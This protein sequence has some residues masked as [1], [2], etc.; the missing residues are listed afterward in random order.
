M[1]LYKSVLTGIVLLILS[2][3]LL[4]SQELQEFEFPRGDVRV[5]FY[6]VENLFDIYNDSL[7]NDDEFTP[8]GIRFWT[9]ERYQKKLYNISKV[10]TAIG[11]WDMPEII[12]LSEIENR[13]VLDNLIKKTAL[14]NFEYHIIHKESPDLRGIDVGFLYRKDRFKPLVY[15][16]I[17]VRFPFEDN[18]PSR[19]ILYVEGILRSSDTLH[20]FINHWPSRYGGQIESDRNREFAAS[21]LRHKVD[22]LFSILKDP[23]IIIIGDLNDYPDNNSLLNVLKA[24]TEFDEIEN[25]ELY[26]LS[27]YLQEVKGKGSH[28]YEGKWG[29]LDQIII[30]GT[31]LADKNGL[32][33]TIENAHVFEAPFLLEADQHYTGFVPFRTYVG[34]KF[35]DGYSDHL[36]VYLDLFFGK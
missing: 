18:R 15:E 10:I 6:N 35:H 24:K 20:F 27:W 16:A 9:Y 23:N 7:K 8:E 26:N 1:S 21:V 32:N 19:D 29:I 28:K 3:N 2:S 14:S 12:G 11:Q 25:E 4:F 30:S 13:D 22:S 36:P 5:M 33:T 34:Y 31:L 17:P